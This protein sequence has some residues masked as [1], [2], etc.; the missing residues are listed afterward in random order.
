MQK[1]FATALLL[2]LTTQ[3]SAADFTL[4]PT[5]NVSGTVVR[6]GDVCHIETADAREQATLAGLELG[7]APG[8]GGTRYW[9]QRE[10]QD[11]LQLLGYNLAEHRSLLTSQ[12]RSAKQNNNVGTKSLPW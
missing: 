5:A 10:V 4:K 2:T 3:L 8:N 1:F 12:G 9:H 6:L 7:P 11:R